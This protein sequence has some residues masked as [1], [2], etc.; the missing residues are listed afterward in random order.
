[1]F[2]YIKPLLYL[3]WTHRY[4]CSH[5]HSCNATLTTGLCAS[6]AHLCYPPCDPRVREKQYGATDNIRHGTHSSVCSSRTCE[7]SFLLIL[8]GVRFALIRQHALRVVSGLRHVVT[9]FSRRIVRFLRLW[10]RKGFWNG[11]WSFGRCRSS[12]RRGGSCG[13]GGGWYQWAVCN[14]VHGSKQGFNI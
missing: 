8:E 1:M 13:G 10:C 6:S 4:S 9:I 5:L 2:E 3:Q 14:K 7:S 11:V 12:R